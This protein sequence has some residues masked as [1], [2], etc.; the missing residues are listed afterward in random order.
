MGFGEDIRHSFNLALAPTGTFVGIQ[1]SLII[2][3]FC[4]FSRIR[5][6]WLGFYAQLVADFTGL[7]I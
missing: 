6:I 1:L 4:G 2:F 5:G 3:W 7:E